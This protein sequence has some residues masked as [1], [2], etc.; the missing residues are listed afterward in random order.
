M[1]STKS[2][3]AFYIDISICHTLINVYSLLSHEW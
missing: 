1:F 2:M 3:L